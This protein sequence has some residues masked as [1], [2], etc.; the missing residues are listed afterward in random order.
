MKYLRAA[1]IFKLIKR[2]KMK[3]WMI[4]NLPLMIKDR[5]FAKIKTM[6]VNIQIITSNQ[7]RRST[8]NT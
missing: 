3:N 2:R 4:K 7:S 6:M 8:A 1:R 5:T